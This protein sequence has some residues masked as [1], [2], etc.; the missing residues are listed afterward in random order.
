VPFGVIG[1]EMPAVGGVPDDRPIVHPLSI[2]KLGGQRG[3]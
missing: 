3:G 1:T 2:Y